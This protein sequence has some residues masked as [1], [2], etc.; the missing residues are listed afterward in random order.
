[1]TPCPSHNRISFNIYL[2]LSHLTQQ[3]TDRRIGDMAITEPDCAIHGHS[4]YMHSS[5]SC[6]I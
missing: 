1:M 5:Y 2:A 6:Q 4:T 3:Q